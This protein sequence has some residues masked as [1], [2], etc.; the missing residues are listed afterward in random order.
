MRVILDANTLLD[1]LLNRPGLVAES[2][3]V[4]LRCEAGGH[5]MFIAWHGLATAYDLLKRGRT[6]AEAMLAVDR[7]LS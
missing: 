1:V 6:E 5:P 2:E 7:I 4:I 3:A